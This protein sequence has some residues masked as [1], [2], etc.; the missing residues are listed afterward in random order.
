MRGRDPALCDAESFGIIDGLHQTFSAIHRILYLRGPTKR[1]Y[2]HAIIFLRM[3]H[4]YSAT[5][6]AEI[7][8]AF[9]FPLRILGWPQHYILQDFVMDP[10]IEER[11]RVLRGQVLRG[12]A[13]QVPGY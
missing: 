12:Q 6:N 9:Y 2:T 10:N 11:G 7:L 3:M 4:A 1:K 13:L 5:V 8:H